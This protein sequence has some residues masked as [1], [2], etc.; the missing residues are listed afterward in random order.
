[1][2]C[3]AM[4]CAAMLQNNDFIDI[5]TDIGIGIGMRMHLLKRMLSIIGGAGYPPRPGAGG[6]RK[7]EFSVCAPSFLRACS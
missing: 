5:D 1:M 6:P 3:N 7:P 2:R 4:R